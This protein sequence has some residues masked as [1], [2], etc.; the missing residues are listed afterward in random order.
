MVSI[1]PRLPSAR[2]DTNVVAGDAAAPTATYTTAGRDAGSEHVHGHGR[3]AGVGGQR[4]DGDDHRRHGRSPNANTVAAEVDSAPATSTVVI[5]GTVTKAAIVAAINGLTGYSATTT[6]ASGDTN[7]VAVDGHASGRR[8]ALAGG[9]AASGGLAQDSVFASVGP[10]RL[11]SV[12]L[13]SRHV[14]HPARRRPSTWCRTPRASRPRST[15]RRSNCSR[16]AYGSDA[17]VDVELIDE[18]AGGT[19]RTGDRRRRPRQRHRHRGLGQRHQRQ[20]RRQRDLDQHRD[21]ST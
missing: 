15:A 20:G 11:G 1:S 8:H 5:N 19:I 9:V 2:R 16:R 18:A 17:F 12:Q 6:A 10:D 7:Y 3:P 13:R 4:R 21:A 14:D